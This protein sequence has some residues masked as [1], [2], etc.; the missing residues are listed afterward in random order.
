MAPR[1]QQ[2]IEER[3]TGTTVLGIKASK[4]KLLPIPLPPLPE[5]EMIVAKLEDVL[6][7]IERLEKAHADESAQ[8]ALTAKVALKRLVDDGD[9]LVFDHFHEMIHTA[10]D[11]AELERSILRLAVSGKLAPQEW[12]DGTGHDLL[13]DVLRLRNAQGSRA[14][15][16]APATIERIPRSWARCTLGDVLE[17]NYGKSLG[18]ELRRDDGKFVAFGANGPIARTDSSL[19]A[20]DGIVIGRKGSA[21]AVNLVRGPFWPTDVTYFVPDGQFGAFDLKYLEYLLTSLNLPALSGG[22]KPGLNRKEAYKLPV[23]LPPLKEQVRIAA[24]VTELF[25]KLGELRAA[26]AT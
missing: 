5:Q 8:R 20:Q 16:T 23:G 21:G 14:T 4:L 3:A 18:K 17:L 26:L 25:S 7:L 22:I 15:L 11:V 1:P 2:L 10:N 9:R 19:V 24:K 12:G 6:D 13:N